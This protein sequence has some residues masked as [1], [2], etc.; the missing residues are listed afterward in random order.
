MKVHDPLG[1]WM[2]PPPQVASE[3]QKSRLLLLSSDDRDKESESSLLTAALPKQPLQST[4]SQTPSSPL[5]P[6]LLDTFTHRCIWQPATSCKLV[7]TQMTELGRARNDR[8][9]RGM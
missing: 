5:L 4:S 1:T 3:E 6:V 7:V 9:D 8:S 2:C